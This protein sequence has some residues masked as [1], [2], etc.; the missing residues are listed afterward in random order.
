M[1]EPLQVSG[2][3]SEADLKRLTRAT[4]SSTIGPTALYYAGVTAPIIS[5]GVAMLIRE[6]LILLHASDY[7]QWFGSALM[8]AFAGITWFL[9]FMRWSY[10]SALGRGTELTEKTFVEAGP[11]LIVR[12]SGIETRI[13]WAAI[14]KV[15]Q[16]GKATTLVVR[17][18]DAVMIPDAWFASKGE[19]DAFV[20]Q[21]R[22]RTRG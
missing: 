18:A 19:R 7:W 5:A 13:D 17:G 16:G 20:S 6:S 10:R 14:D 4:R 1:S 21:V 11:Q 9:I 3:L 8:A 12:R 15:Q 2:L 22:K